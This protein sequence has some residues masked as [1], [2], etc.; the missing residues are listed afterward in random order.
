MDQ[1]MMFK[2]QLIQRQ[3]EDL[4]DNISVI[5]KELDDLAKY[6]QYLADFDKATES[7]MMSN[8]GKGIHVK[9]NLANKEL[10]LEVGAGV[11]VKK[12]PVQ[13]RE[14]IQVQM[15]KLAEAKYH[16]LGKIELYQQAL[17][18]MVKEMEEKE[19][20]SS[21]DHSHEHNHEHSHDNHDHHNHNHDH[22][23]KKENPNTK[24]KSS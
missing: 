6:D 4:E 11:I 15:K 2:A 3:V 1:E 18:G 23:H 20:S 17:H 16:V 7:A 8:M 19:S 14:I 21:H 24:K 5:E 13:A 9:G 22:N 12:T 10:Y